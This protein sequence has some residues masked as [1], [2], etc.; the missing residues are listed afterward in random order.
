MPISIRVGT[1]RPGVFLAGLAQR[2]AEVTGK[3]IAREAVQDADALKY[4]VQDQLDAIASS[5]QQV[6][7]IFD[8]LDEAL[9]GSFDPSIIPTRLPQTLRVLLSA[10]W[11]VGD[12]VENG[13]RCA[14]EQFEGVPRG[15]A[16]DVQAAWDVIR[17]RPNRTAMIRRGVA[18][19]ACPFF[20]QK[21]RTQHAG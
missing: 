19:R 20:D 13:W 7:V 11:Q 4:V 12:V 15:F 1:N 6:L 14:W 17:R 5:G 3:P 10:R 21:H 9:Q 18:L 8:G 2:L 16:S